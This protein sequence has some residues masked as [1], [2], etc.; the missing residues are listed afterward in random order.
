MAI[1]EVVPQRDRLVQDEGPGGAMGVVT[2][3]WLR[4]LSAVREAING[5]IGVASD[6]PFSAGDFTGGTAGVVGVGTMTWT[7]PEAG[8]EVNRARRDGARLWWLVSLTGT[9][10]GGTPSTALRLQLPFGARGPAVY[11]TLPISLA[12]EGSTP[13]PAYG[14]VRPDE[15]DV[16][17]VIKQD[18]TAWTA[19][20]VTVQFNGELEVVP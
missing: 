15:P 12:L 7:V 5:I 18:R 1:L 2:P 8:V 14:R 13:V 4:W 20:A 6:V 19:G 16:L 17:L 11:Q 9:T 3:R 10:V